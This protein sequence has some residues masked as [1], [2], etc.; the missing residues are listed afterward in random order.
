[1]S[2]L[3]G[4][5]QSVAPESVA[6]FEVTEEQARRWAKD[7]LGQA[8]E[9]LKQNADEKL[10]ELRGKLDE[11]NKRPVREG[12]T[13]TPDVGPALLELLKQLPRVV[14]QSLSA[15][16]G[17]VEAARKVMADLQGRLKEAGIELDER[18]TSFPDRLA[19]LRK[20]T[21]REKP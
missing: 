4:R 15:D 16:E 6:V 3:L 10:A 18:F 1:M 12:T 2:D 9:E 19:E 17:R 13:I 21:E 20:E 8:L 5:S 11:F 14:G 7:Q